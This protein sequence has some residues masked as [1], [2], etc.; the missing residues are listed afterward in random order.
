MTMKPGWKTTEFWFG[1][2]L[3]VGIYLLIWFKRYP[4][5]GDAGYEGVEW[6][7]G[8][9]AAFT[10]VRT[11]LKRAAPLGDLTDQI[12]S[13]TKTKETIVSSSTSPA[14]EALI[15]KSPGTQEV[16]ASKT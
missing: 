1:F 13:Q 14:A 12:S 8:I 6:L 2:L 15:Q 4:A 3:A 16:P 11:V 10:G 7:M 9:W 5:H